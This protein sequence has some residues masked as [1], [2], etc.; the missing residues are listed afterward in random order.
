MSVKR[1]HSVFCVF[2]RHKTNQ[3][4]IFNVLHY[5]NYTF[6]LM[7]LRT[8]SF[9]LLLFCLPVLL[10]LSCTKDKTPDNADELL[11]DFTKDTSG[12][13]WY[14]FSDSLLP[15]SSGSGHGQPFLRTRYNAVAAGY[16]DAEGKVVD[17][18]I[19]PNGSVIIKELYKADSTLDQY[20]I[21]W[22]FPESPSADANGW[23]WGYLKPNGQTVTSAG[24]KGATCINCHSQQ[25]HIDQTLMNAYFP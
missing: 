5:K 25:G 2:I 14:H 3:L 16:L 15:R 6:V 12:Y 24:L 18:T 4:R 13:V 11:F 22:K 17:G 23:V 20:A 10:F 9:Q 7:R 21:L 8:F 1:N 19:F